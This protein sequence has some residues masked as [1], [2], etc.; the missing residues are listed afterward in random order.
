MQ[1][2]D[3]K[4]LVVKMKVENLTVNEFFSFLVKHNQFYREARLT[5]PLYGPTEDTCIGIYVFKR[6]F[7]KWHMLEK[8]VSMQQH[9]EQFVGK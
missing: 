9:F 2:F 1:H 5:C 6:V 4:Q 8:G 7:N 3:T